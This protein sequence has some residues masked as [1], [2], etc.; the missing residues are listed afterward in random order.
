LEVSR[1]PTLILLLIALDLPGCNASGRQRQDG[2][3]KITVAVVRSTSATI[4]QSYRC[5][6]ESPRNVHVRTRAA[7]RLAAILVKEGQAVKRNDLLFRVRPTGDKE[8]PKAENRD[9][10]VSIK[11]PCDGLVVG[12]LPSLLGSRARKGESLA[13]LSDD[14]A[15]WVHFDMPESHYLAF[16]A[17]GR[18]DWRSLELELLLSDRS[19]YPH[20]GKIA[21]VLGSFHNET[22]DITLVAE[23]PNPDGVLRRGQ[24]GTL[25][26]KRELKD[27]ILIPQR[28]TFDDHAKRY[29][30]VL[31]EDHV[32]HQREIVTQGDVEDL[33][34]IKKGV[35]V[36]DK[37]VLEG[38]GRF[39]TVTKW[40]QRRFQTPRDPPRPP[41]DQDTR[42]S[43]TGLPP[44]CTPRRVGCHRLLSRWIA[45]WSWQ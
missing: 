34:V 14:R 24:T 27:A 5:R 4:K 35:G 13:T 3:K 45:R 39:A 17:E 1:V 29:V 6:I 15:T 36:G 44:A 25:L 9:E 32:A 11:A 43:S 19:K 21:Q 23:F 30:Y 26:M 20:A 2:A 10:V 16:M 42:I 12:P 33:F 18:K 7:G 41:G 8:K 31:D 28:A 22:G 40:N 38:S 37:I